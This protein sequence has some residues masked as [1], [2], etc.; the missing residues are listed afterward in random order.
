MLGITSPEGDRRNETKRSEKG[1]K[2]GAKHEKTKQTQ[3]D[4]QCH[5]IPAEP[6]LAQAG[7]PGS[8]ATLLDYEIA[9]QTQL[10]SFIIEKQGFYEK[11]S[12]FKP[13]IETQRRSQTRFGQQN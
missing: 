11:Q 13:K 5:V 1:M 3:T 7:K 12:Q 10:S 9:K 6:V 4:R 2:E 8:R